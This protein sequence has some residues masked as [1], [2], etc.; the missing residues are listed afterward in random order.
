[1]AVKA[2]FQASSCTGK[3][4]YNFQ[5][6]RRVAKNVSQRHDEPMQ[7]YHCSWCHGW[8][9]GQPARSGKR[10]RSGGKNQRGAER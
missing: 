2:D 1:M 6:A 10:G 5:H 8:H 9:I 7:P 4:T 3:K